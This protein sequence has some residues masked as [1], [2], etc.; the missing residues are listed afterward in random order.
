[1]QFTLVLASLLSLTSAA[2]ITKR[3]PA[4]LVDRQSG[5]CGALRTPLCCQLDVLG[6]ATLNCANGTVILSNL[7]HKVRMNCTDYLS[8]GPVTSA[9]EFEALC[10]ETGTSAQCCILPVGADGLLCTGA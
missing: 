9:E 8:A 3:H 6:V 1:M 10:A 5:V 7:P 2:A 4:T